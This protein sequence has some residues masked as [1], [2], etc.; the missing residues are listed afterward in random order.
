V[1]RAFAALHPR[2][3]SEAVLRA[4]FGAGPVQASWRTAFVCALL[5]CVGFTA[6]CAPSD[7]PA[8]G[9]SE[10]EALA[11]SG[12]FPPFLQDM[13]GVLDD[14]HFKGVRVHRSYQVVS[15]PGSASVLLTSEVLETREVVASDGAGSYGIELVDAIRLPSSIDPLAFP[16]TFE[17][18][19]DSRWRLREFRVRDFDAMLGNYAVVA[20]GITTTVAGRTCER[21][22][23]SRYVA[24]E[25]R[26]GHYVLDVDP[27]TAFVLA[28]CE[29]DETGAT[30][31]EFE[32][33][34][35]EF[36]GDLSGVALRDGE[37]DQDP[38]DLHAPLQTQVSFDV[39]V[40]DLL[41]DGF[42]FVSGTQIDVPA[43][44]APA[45]TDPMLPAGEWVRLE[46][47]DGVEALRFAHAEGV[48]LASGGATSVMRV[49]EE[50]AWRVAFGRVRGVAIVCSGRVGQHSL[51]RIIESAF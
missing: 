15:D 10:P 6:S 43:G 42:E 11:L 2:A 25:T 20:P 21:I 46:A 1:R 48:V 41:P 17:R 3:G 29:L 51:Q 44:L 36:G 27:T 16:I 47:T 39:L 30:I 33:E 24:T 22:E 13:E 38:I 18:S 34:S 26:P 9:A 40:P 5:A 49:V 37:F 32:Y 8:D 45:G 28:M 7:G 14:T 50:G 19:V 31:Q 23:L 35:I 4:R 12:S